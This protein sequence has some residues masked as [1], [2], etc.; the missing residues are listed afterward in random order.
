MQL[1]MLS[2]D[3]EKQKRAREIL[4]NVEDRGKS[5]L[6]GGWKDEHDAATLGSEVG[7]DAGSERIE[8]SRITMERVAD[9]LGEL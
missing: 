2:S 5:W 8:K 4:L 7:A 1:G 3:L 9:G 6:Q